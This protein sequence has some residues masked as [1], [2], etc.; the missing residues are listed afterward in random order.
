MSDKISMESVLFFV[1]LSLGAMTWACFVGLIY[2]AL[3]RQFPDL[4]FES[5]KVRYQASPLAL[6]LILIGGVAFVICAVLW[7]NSSHSTV[8][9]TANSLLMALWTAAAVFDIGA[10]MFLWSE[11]EPE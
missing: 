11:S 5:G 1:Q 4:L 8:V 10:L 3:E 2:A 7:L 9:S 6:G